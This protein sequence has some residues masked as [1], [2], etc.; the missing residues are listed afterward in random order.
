MR[1][2]LLAAASAL[3]LGA[4]GSSPPPTPAAAAPAGSTAKQG[5]ANLAPASGSLV[6]GKITLTP[7]GDGVHLT[8]VVGGL[9]ANST[10]G[11]H[12]HE[13]GDCSAADATSA[14]PHFNPA[15][16][17]HGRAGGGAHHAGDMDNIVADAE[18]VARVS[19]HV[20]GVTLGGG[21]ANDIANRAL[22]VH[23]SPDDYTSQPAGNAGA[24]VACGV[25]AVTE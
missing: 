13:K 11:F 12:V 18:G 24:R 6:S 8:G 21:A 17:G 25:I 7:M 9:P 15:G 2:V 19:V 20:M 14:G 5:I 3:V 22:V 10:H 16:S 4:C 1:I 23:A